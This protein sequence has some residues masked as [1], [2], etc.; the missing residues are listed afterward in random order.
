MVTGDINPVISSLV[1]ISTGLDKVNA[2][3]YLRQ[4]DEIFL[5]EKEAKTAGISHPENFIRAKSIQYWHEKN[6]KAEEEIIKM[7]EG[8]SDLDQLDIFRQKKLADTTMQF[9]Q[10]FLK[11]KWLQS[12]L[13]ISQAMQY[14]HNF[15]LDEKA[16]LTPAF[17]ETIGSSHQSIKDYLCYV[18]LDFTL[19]DP[20]LEEVPAGWSFQFAEDMQLKDTYDAIIKKEMKLSDKKLQQYKQKSLAAYYEVKENEGEQIYE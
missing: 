2:D 20:S 4:A 8:I 3:T 19:L 17:A 12:T 6:E 14:F 9:L 11:P 16:L 1:K 5:N 18:L 15:S 13:V 7:I 10:L